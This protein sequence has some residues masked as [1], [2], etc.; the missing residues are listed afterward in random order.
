[1]SSHRPQPNRRA[2]TRRQAVNLMTDR[3]KPVR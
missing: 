3:V 1:M 2:G